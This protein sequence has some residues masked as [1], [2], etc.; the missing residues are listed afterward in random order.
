M[1]TFPKPI[2]FDDTMLYVFIDRALRAQREGRR[3]SG[4]E[5]LAN[6]DEETVRTRSWM[7]AESAMRDDPDALRHLLRAYC[8]TK[9]VTELTVRASTVNG[10]VDIEVTERRAVA[11]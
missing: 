9:G 4:A 7:A 5:L 3:A 8:R 10:E 1:S 11:A 6:L 2:L